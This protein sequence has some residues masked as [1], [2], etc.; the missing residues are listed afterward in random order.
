L[1]LTEVRPPLLTPDP[2]KVVLI[3]PNAGTRM[4]GEAIK[5]YQ[6]FRWLLDHDID[7]VLI[8]HGRNRGELEPRL[9]ADRVLWI[10]ET[11]LQASL[12]RSRV[13][14]PLVSVYFHLAAARLAR[15]FDRATTLVHYISPIS[16]V[17][18]RF[19]PRGYRVVM[20]PLNGNL[21]YP[22]AFLNRVGRKRRLEE[23]LYGLIQR[24]GGAVFGDKRKAETVLVSGGERTR[25]ALRLAGVAEG[26]MVDVLD[27]GVSMELIGL[28]PARH[29]GRNPHFVALGRFDAYK[30]YDL[31]IRA[32]AAAD[33]DIRVTIFGDG[34]M[35]DPLQE[36]AASLGVT[37]RVA[38]PGWLAHEDLPELRRYRGFVF[39][40]LAEAN[41]IVI[42]EAMM[43][44]LPVLTLRWGGPALLADDDSALFIDPDGEDAVV[45]GLAD[46]MNLLARDPDLAARIGAAARTRAQATFGWDSVAASW[47]AYY[48]ADGRAPHRRHRG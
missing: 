43:L 42:Q 1:T 11:P 24:V 14:R 46:G 3:A 7:A 6:Y 28:E 32:V 35:H 19:P 44:G 34:Y 48:P 15:S 23:A 37:E 31:T 13:L 26:R 22:P 10:E 36:L 5:A 18:L 30:A 12:W 16:P 17:A 2:A 8:T 29:E 25:A 9:P 38:F 45:A 41:G 40:T 33:S 47:A 21:G 4:G 39:P 27:A 20:G